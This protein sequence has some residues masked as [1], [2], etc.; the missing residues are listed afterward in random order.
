MNYMYLRD[1]CVRIIS[2]ILKR[3]KGAAPAV[4]QAQ[5]SSIKYETEHFYTCF[6]R[7]LLI[8]IASG[9]IFQGLATRE[10]VSDL[11]LSYFE[12]K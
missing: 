6:T 1:L 10:H 5:S 3:V 12:A 7:A 8:S 2:G 11:V 4:F 9:S